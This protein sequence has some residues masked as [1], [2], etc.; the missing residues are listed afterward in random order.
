MSSVKDVIHDA[1]GVQIVAIAVQLS[2]RSVYKWIE[3]NAFP[4]SEYTGES[5]YVN[6]IAELSKKFS[7]EKILKIGMP[8]KNK[9]ITN[10]SQITI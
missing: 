1:G 7:K 4:R 2:E 5:N 3:K 10:T 8:K 6:V 9:T